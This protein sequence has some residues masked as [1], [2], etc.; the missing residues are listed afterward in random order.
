MPIKGLEKRGGVPASLVL[1]RDK[2]R[3]EKGPIQQKVFFPSSS[4][5]LYWEQSEDLLLFILFDGGCFVFAV[6]DYPEDSGEECT[7]YAVPHAAYCRR[8]CRF[9]RIGEMHG[10]QIGGKSGVLHTYFNG[11]STLLRLA[12]LGQAAHAVTENVT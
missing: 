5:D 12:H 10:C 6:V 3:R 11:N 2:L 7:R 4:T 9:G 8:Q 1:C